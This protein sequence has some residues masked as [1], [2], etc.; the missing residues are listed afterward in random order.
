[1]LTSSLIFVEGKMVTIWKTMEASISESN[2]QRLCWKTKSWV[3]KQNL[4]AS[5]NSG[6]SSVA[7]M[8][9]TCHDDETLQQGAVGNTPSPPQGSSLQG[10]TISSSCSRDENEES[11][12]Q[13]FQDISMNSDES[14]DESSHDNTSAHTPKQ[15]TRKTVDGVE[16]EYEWVQ[17]NAGNLDPNDLDYEDFKAHEYYIDETSQGRIQNILYT[18]NCG[19]QYKCR[20]NISAVACHAERHLNHICT[21]RYAT[22]F[23]FKGNWDGEGKVTKAFWRSCESKGIRIFN[24]KGAFDIAHKRLAM[25][26]PREEW[27]NCSPCDPHYQLQMRH[28]EQYLIEGTGGHFSKDLLNRTPPGTVLCSDDGIL[29]KNMSTIDRRIFKFAT[30]NKYKY[31][32]ASANDTRSDTVFIDDR[33]EIIRDPN[34]K[35][36]TRKNPFCKT[37]AG[38]TTSKFEFEGTDENISITDQYNIKTRKMYCSCPNCKLRKKDECLYKKEL[39][40]AF[41]KEESGPLPNVMATRE[42]FT[43]LCCGRTFFTRQLALR[44]VVKQVCNELQKIEYPQLLEPLYVFNHPEY[45]KKNNTQIDIERTYLDYQGVFERCIAQ[46]DDIKSKSTSVQQENHPVLQCEYDSFQ[47]L[48]WTLPVCERGGSDT[49]TQTLGLHFEESTIGDSYNMPILT[50]MEEN[51]T[52][53]S[54]TRENIRSNIWFASINGIQVNHINDINRIFSKESKDDDEDDD[55]DDDDDND[56][57]DEERGI[58]SRSRRYQIVIYTGK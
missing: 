39:E 45:G 4:E 44:H 52:C 28:K 12:V 30:R 32:T 16:C 24:A 11:L 18:D 57:N 47:I 3:A 15:L 9:P 51:S 36:A 17:Y 56:D 27:A 8:P 38:K 13:A 48:N 22:K 53:F 40:A 31:F 54:Q 21:H 20:F 49:S 58:I 34:E 43:C 25:A 29:N 14:S 10:S 41:G 2:N 55:D 1:M 46:W 33:K 26:G 19:N 35:I 5:R 23:R 37:L 7:S 42:V 50:K 6:T